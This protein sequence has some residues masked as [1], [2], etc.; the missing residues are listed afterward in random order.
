MDIWVGIP[1][2]NLVACLRP[3]HE[4][5]QIV[6]RVGVICSFAL[7]DTL[8][9][10]AAFR[11]VRSYFANKQLVLFC[12][13]QNIAA[14]EL[15]PGVDKLV[16]VDLLKPLET[17]SRMRDQ[18][19]DLLL[20]FSSWQRLTA[21][22]SMMAGASFTVGFRTAGQHRHR[23]YDRVTEHTR[24]R[25]EVDNFRALLQTVNITGHNAP[26]IAPPAIPQPEL[27]T[28]GK[29]I[30]VF[31][32]WPSGVRSQTREWPEDRW[33]TLAKRLAAD[34]NQ[35]DFLFVITGS[36]SDQVR[37]QLF[38]QRLRAAGLDAESFCRPGPVRL[39]V[40]DTPACQACR[41]CQ[42]RRNAS[43]RYS[44]RSDHLP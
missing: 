27:L 29:Q 31:H 18:H 36:P 35:G 10:S 24:D 22:Y 28:R 40:P 16:M 26:H 3:K 13:P 20:D 14:A 19:L 1:V 30:V 17:I 7:G 9:F 11:S 2:L 32:M 12:G 8:L 33:I 21:F 34:S 25:H 15:I 43:C 38:V 41:Q 5:P 4:Y 37:S 42:Y 6:E 23:G 39:S 44:G